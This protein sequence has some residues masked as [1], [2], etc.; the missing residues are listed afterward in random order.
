LKRALVVAFYFAPENTS[1]THRSLHFARRLV[2]EGIEVT[3]LS[4]Q[5]IETEFI[6]V[7]SRVAARVTRP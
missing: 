2:D 7:A 1:G 5:T 3:L 6:E 4:K